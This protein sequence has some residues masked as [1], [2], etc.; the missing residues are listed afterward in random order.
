MNT[1][2]QMKINRLNELYSKLE[3]GYQLSPLEL[4][5]QAV[6]RDEVIAYF[7][8]AVSKV[9]PPPKK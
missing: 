4:N 7:K 8:M 2:V 6:L 1:N 3:R 9:Q 5:E